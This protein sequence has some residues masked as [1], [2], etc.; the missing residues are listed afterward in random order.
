[1][2]VGPKRIRDIF[3]RA[4]SCPEGCIVFIDELDAIGTRSEGIRSS[5]E[6]TATINQLLT[7]LDGF[8][9]NTNIVVIGATNRIDLVDSALIRAG[10]FDLK[11]RLETPKKDDRLGIFKTLIE[12]KH[13]PNEISGTAMSQVAEQAEGW[14][15]ADI[16]TLINESI[17]KAI[18]ANCDSIH[19]DHILQAFQEMRIK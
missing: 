13:V 2:G 15:G 4:K 8:E 17:F 3:K 14:C 10:R 12:K 11:I 18:R 5:R 16:E 1:V 9:E 7:E 19:D 6:T